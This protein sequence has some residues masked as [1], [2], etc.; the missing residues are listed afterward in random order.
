MK[1]IKNCIIILI[2]LIFSENILYAQSNLEKGWDAF[3]KNNRKEARDFFGKAMSDANSKA[4]ASLALAFINEVDG[5][6][7]AAFKNFQTF[8][9]TSENPYPYLYALW[10]RPVVFSYDNKLD[11]DKIDF[12][13]TIINDPKANGTLKAMAHASLGNHYAATNNSSKSNEE[14]DKIG[15]I[16]QWQLAGEFEN[17]SA[18]GF[19]KTY[20]PI[21]NPQSSSVFTNKNGVKVKW[22]TIVG[23]RMD[24]WVDLTYHLFTNNSII[25][26]QTFINSPTDQQVQLRIGTSGSIKAWVND[27]LVLF[28]SEELNNDLDTYNIGVKLNKGNNRVLLQ[29]GSSEID[30]SNF[31]VRITDENGNPIE[32]LQA[33]SEYQDYAKANTPVFTLHKIFAEDYFENKIKQEPEQICNYLILSAAYLRNDKA[34]EARKILLSAE[35]KEPECSYIKTDLIEAY[36]RDDNETEAGI[37][38]E[39]LKEHDAENLLSMN[40]FY[41]EEIKKESYEEAQKILKNIESAYGEDEASISKKIDLLGNLKMRDEML[42]EIEKAYS[43]YPEY[44]DFVNLKSLVEQQINKN[45]NAGVD[46]Y[47]KYLKNNYSIDAQKSLSTAYFAKGDA[48]AGLT[49]YASP[50]AKYA[51]DKLFCASIE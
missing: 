7:D 50:F 43:K 30:R 32:S 41:N 46:V 18:S 5:K 10:H 22:F 17:I 35:K 11:A 33:S 29:I 31:L 14:Y 3:Y 8:F 13:K 45:Y 47:K 24:K 4:E 44:Y 49:A 51:V 2:L 16:A 40:L 9:S 20:D 21:S 34:Y 42:Q 38:I 1:T 25:Y 27:A 36:A 26:A 37:A 15:S 28:E 48:Q 39:W 6:N 12:L 23:N 19:D